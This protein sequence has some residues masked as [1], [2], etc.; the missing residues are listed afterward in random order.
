ML[1]SG[2]VDEECAAIVAEEALQNIDT[3]RLRHWLDADARPWSEIVAVF[4]QAG[5]GLAAA[6]EAGLVHRDF[7]PE[8]V[9][10]GQD[11]RVRVVDFGLVAADGDLPSVQAEL[12]GASNPDLLDVDA[13]LTQTGELM[14][15][16]AYMAPEQF[17]GEAPTPASDQFSFFA[18]LFEALEDERPFAGDAV[19]TLMRSVLAGDS[20][21]MTRSELPK[22]LR[23]TV[24]RGLAREP[25]QRFAN[26]GS[27]LTTDERAMRVVLSTLHERDKLFMDSRTHHETVAATVAES[28]GLPHAQRQVFLDHDPD[29]A[30]MAAALREAIEQAK[31]EPT[32]AIGHPSRALAAVLEQGLAEAYEEGVAVFPLSEQIAREGVG[33]SVQNAVD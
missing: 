29:P 27:A 14:G 30:A 10:V 21:S 24:A 9:V 18:A 6:H 7:K 11:G 20:R 23:E 26:M 22:A 31:V 16:P 5:R 12:A 32:I 8:N 13:P 28:L 15:T 3:G 1:P 4:E 25:N 17:L 2:A 33:R 19:P